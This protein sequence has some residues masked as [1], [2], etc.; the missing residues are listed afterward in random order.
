M[1]PGVQKNTSLMLRGEAPQD[2]SPVGGMVHRVEAPRGDSEHQ[3]WGKEK[4]LVSLEGGNN[5]GPNNCTSSLYGVEGVERI[6]RTAYLG[7]KPLAVGPRLCP[8]RS[9]GL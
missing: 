3:D 7:R 6:S 2:P 8:H 1:H 4:G 5:T 9:L